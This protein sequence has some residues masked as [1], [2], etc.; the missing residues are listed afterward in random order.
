MYIYI[1]TGIP[2]AMYYMV[3]TIA[4]YGGVY[5]LYMYIV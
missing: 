2:A 1:Y 3:V 5:V 4:R